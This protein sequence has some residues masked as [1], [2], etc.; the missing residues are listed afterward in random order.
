MIV[1]TN[2]IS[3][4]FAKFASSKKIVT[5]R[6]NFPSMSHHNVSPMIQNSREDKHTY[7][8]DF[9]IDYKMQPT[10]T[11]THTPVAHTDESVALVIIEHTQGRKLTNELF[12]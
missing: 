12:I 2:E 10:L 3:L 7:I 4:A 9:S 1:F 11:H 8:T 5:L 6:C